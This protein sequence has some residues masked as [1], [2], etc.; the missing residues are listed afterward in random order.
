MAAR[1]GQVETVDRG[2]VHPDAQFALARLPRPV[3]R[4][5]GHGAARRAGRSAPLR[6][7]TLKYPPIAESLGHFLAT[8]AGPD[9]GC[10]RNV[11]GIKLLSG[12]F[13]LSSSTGH[14]G[15]PSVEVPP[16]ERR[17]GSR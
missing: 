16:K 3:T 15:P 7:T 4:P 1:D 14:T 5:P 6:R 13:P 10:G 17:P 2:G 11:S 8:L 12:P 9:V